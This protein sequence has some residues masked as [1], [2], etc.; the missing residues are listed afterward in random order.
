MKNLIEIFFVIFI[1]FSPLIR[2][3]VKL[4]L[5][6]LLVLRNLKYI[7]IKRIDISERIGKFKVWIVICVFL[8][9]NL[10]N[11]LIS[12]LKFNFNVQATGFSIYVIIC[13]ILGYILSKKYSIEFFLESLEKIIFISAVISI[14]SFLIILINPIV[15]QKFISYNYYHT[16][17]KT[18]FLNNFLMNNNM[19]ILRNS[20]I[21][22]EPGAYQFLLNIAFF[23]YLFF[24]KKKISLLKCLIYFMAI[25]STYSST[26][27]V[28]LLINLFLFYKRV[29]YKNYF[30]IIIILVGIP[31]ALIILIP[32]L[33][34]VIVEKLF[35]GGI[36]LTGRTDGVKELFEK[37]DIELLLGIGNYEAFI[38]KF[39]TFDSYTQIVIRYGSIFLFY[40]IYRILRINNLYITAIILLSFTNETIWF[41]PLITPFYYYQF[42]NLKKGERN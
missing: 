16:T 7:K 19:P 37:F 6:T 39:R 32:I 12:I 1:S 21:A 38:Y 41:F 4:I 24:L 9:L 11:E 8:I 22:W 42:K 10:V 13:F 20:G 29:S 27:I 18:I 28:I 40:L 34:K 25:I 2:I 31:I 15:V 26:G 17:H 5:S 35:S 33:N 14:I 23:S 30:K 3:E 36:G